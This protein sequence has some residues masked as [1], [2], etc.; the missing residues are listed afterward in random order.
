L[1]KLG[2]LFF[3][4]SPEAKDADY[5]KTHK[6][7]VNAG[8]FL[9]SY[10][11]V[12]KS[13]TS[14]SAGMPSVVNAWA[15]QRSATILMSVFLFSAFATAKPAPQITKFHKYVV[16]AD[17][18][19]KKLMKADKANVLTALGYDIGLRNWIRVNKDGCNEIMSFS[20]SA[21]QLGAWFCTPPINPGIKRI[22][23]RQG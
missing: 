15:F 22:S 19:Y 6:V 9:K 2:R 5:D 14:R 12:N 8:H 13:S 7:C 20:P 17:G 11:C 23:C 18:I 10:L 16:G 21:Q 1:R 3:S 4:V